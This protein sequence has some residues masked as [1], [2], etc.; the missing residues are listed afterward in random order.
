LY[1]SEGGK[2]ASA[3]P[4]DQSTPDYYMAF[5]LFK[6]MLNIAERHLSLHPESKKFPFIYP[7]VFSN[8]NKK[9]PVANSKNF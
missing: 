1:G 2:H 7:L 3:A 9:G 8:D 4:P 6:Y 5:R